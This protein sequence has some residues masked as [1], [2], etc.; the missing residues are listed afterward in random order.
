MIIIVAIAL[1]NGKK[2]ELAK[3]EWIW[4]AESDDWYEPNFLEEVLK[5]EI[6]N[7]NEVV[8]SFGQSII[9]NNNNISVYQNSEKLYET[10]NGLGFVQKK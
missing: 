7:D 1:C 5:P 3:G 10:M 9:V 2:I 6:V 4:I 8:L